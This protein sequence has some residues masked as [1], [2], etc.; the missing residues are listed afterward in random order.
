M[1]STSNSNAQSLL[2]TGKDIFAPR[3]DITEFKHRYGLLFG[4]AVGLTFAVAT[5]GFD[6]VW[7]NNANGLQPWVKLL[8]GAIPCVVIGGITGRVSAQLDKSIL[9]LL[10]W[11]IAG[12]GF[13]WLT[14]A[15]PIQA[16]PRLI[17][18]VEPGT[19]GLLNYVYYEGFNIR[20]GV[21]YAWITIFVGIV[22]LLQIPLSDSGVFSTSTGGKL[23]PIFVIMI[24]MGICGF[25]VD[26]LIN[27]PLRSATT[28]MDETLQFYL[29]HQGKDVDSATARK[30]YL[31]SLREV[32]E[33]IAP[34]YRLIVGSFDE[35]FGEV[36]ILVK[37]QTAW[38]DCA[39]I[40][41]QPILCKEVIRAP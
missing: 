17:A 40:Y 1:D 8:A 38:A 7:L 21:A 2:R 23:A 28:A 10:L 39:V 13:A 12:S 6:A 26:G 30:M 16:A 36:Q 33:H 31:G 18:F 9:A 11:I 14:V 15:V 24:I 34:G 5:W 29:E 22:G 19:Q 25:I 3:R 35:Y 41:D 20:I 4:V 32:E 37:F 27:K